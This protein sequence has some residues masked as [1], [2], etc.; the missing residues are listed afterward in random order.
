MSGTVTTTDGNNPLMSFIERASRDENF[1]IEKFSE[2][3]RLQHEMQREQARQAFDAAMSAAQAEMLPVVRGAK[4][5]HLGNRYATLEAIDTAIRPIYTDH[6]FSVR[7]GS[8][9]APIEGQLRVTCRVAHSGGYSEESHLDSVVSS[10]GSQGGRSATTP[11]QALGSAITYLRRYL[12]GM[13]FNIVTTEG[14]APDDDAEATRRGAPTRPV[15]PRNTL[16]GAHPS[17]E[18]PQPPVPAPPP[19]PPLRAPARTDA[20]WQAWLGRLRLASEGAPTR[21][22][23]VDIGDRPTVKEALNSAPQWVQDDIVDLLT[24][25][26]ARFPEP[27]EP[28]EKDVIAELEKEAEDDGWPGP[29]S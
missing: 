28:E 20:Q 4:N 24:D 9:T 8:G 13:V 21:Q 1:N 14:A 27:P 26:F 2:L 6:G 3:L 18:S 23:V 11:V 10:A 29:A 5:S 16:T 19:P 15:D 7:Y 12:L 17:A 22:D 25:A